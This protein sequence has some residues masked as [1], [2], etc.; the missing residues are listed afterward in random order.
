MAEMNDKVA[1]VGH[2][3]TLTE[4][5]N[6]KIKAQVAGLVQEEDSKGLSAND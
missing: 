4:Q 5:M 2:L 1:M 6:N 3:R